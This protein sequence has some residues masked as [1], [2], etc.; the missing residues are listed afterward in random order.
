[1]NIHI[2]VDAVRRFH[3]RNAFFFSSRSLWPPYRP[4][5]RTGTGGPSGIGAVPQSCTSPAGEGVLRRGRGPA[6]LT[7]TQA[8]YCGRVLLCRG[9][10]VPRI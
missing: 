2:C 1:M 5:A 10:L 4:L 3:P 7:E 8:N 6:A 9:N